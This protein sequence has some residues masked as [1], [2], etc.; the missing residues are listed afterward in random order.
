MIGFKVSVQGRE[1]LARLGVPGAITGRPAANMLRKQAETYKA[2][3]IAEA[4]QGG[5]YL[6]GRQGGALKRAHQIRVLNQYAAEVVNTESYAPYVAGGTRPHWMPPGILPFPALRTIA[7]RGTPANDWMDRAFRK[8]EA[9]V[10][11]NLD[12]MASEI[13][14]ELGQ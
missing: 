7:M 3:A 9:S 5:P 10:K 4:P 13:A 2:L 8:G 12:R 6:N 1:K 14:A 11:G